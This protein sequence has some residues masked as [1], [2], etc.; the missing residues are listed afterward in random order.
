MNFALS[1]FSGVSASIRGIEASA[2][3]SSIRH[4]YATF[5]VNFVVITVISYFILS[6]TLVSIIPIT[7]LILLGP[8]LG[9]IVFMMITSFGCFMGLVLWYLNSFPSW[10]FVGS[11]GVLKAFV[12]IPQLSFLIMNFVF[13]KKADQFMML[14]IDALAN[15]YEADLSK[16]ERGAALRK[17]Y[18]KLEKEYQKPSI[19]QNFKLSMFNL[20]VATT[21]KVLVFVLLL[22]QSSRLYVVD[23]AVDAFTTGFQLVAIYT[24]RIR[25]LHL[26]FHLEWCFGNWP[27]IVGFMFLGLLA[28][29]QI[30]WATTFLSLGM[31]YAATAALVEDLIL[32]EQKQD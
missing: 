8:L 29:S 2:M 10:I 3:S 11:H 25:R 26:A 22:G 4:Q 27:F 32:L 12:T 7:C 23:P 19:L 5:A 15:Y 13:S 20:V 9:P 16:A 21:I 30:G 28:E 1:F 24:I 18:N 14:G 17:A 6:A 31:G